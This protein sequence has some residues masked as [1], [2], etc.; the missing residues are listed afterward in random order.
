MTLA[1]NSQINEEVG[2]AH[3]TISLNFALISTKLVS[4]TTQQKTR[5]NLKI[6]CY[7]VLYQMAHIGPEGKICCLKSNIFGWR[8]ISTELGICLV[9]VCTST[10]SIQHTV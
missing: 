2:V 3:C 8:Y 1:V 9:I 5:K 10:V 7:I 6:T 4:K